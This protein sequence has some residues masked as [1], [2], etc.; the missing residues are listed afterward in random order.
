MQLYMVSTHPAP[1]FYLAIHVS[2]HSI[3]PYSYN[4]SWT[5]LQYLKKTS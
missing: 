4:L 5:Y 2:D 1:N 3:P